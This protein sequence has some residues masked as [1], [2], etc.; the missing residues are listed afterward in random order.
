[1]V[2]RSAEADYLVT[3]VVAVDADSGHNAWLSY[4][5]IQATELAF[6]TFGSHTG[7]IRTART[8]MER[9]AVKQ[10]LVLLVKDNGQPTLSA[11]ITLNLVFA[12]N[13]LEALPKMKNQLSNSDYQSDLQFYLALALL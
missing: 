1:M 13:F 5:L 10:R 9:D 11:S 6:L 12:E 7:E 4:Q 8:F 2:P 3:K